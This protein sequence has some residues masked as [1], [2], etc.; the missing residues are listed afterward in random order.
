MENVTVNGQDVKKYLSDQKSKEIQ[1]FLRHEM[2]GFGWMR[3]R[4]VATSNGT[5]NVSKVKEVGNGNI[6]CK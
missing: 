4:H 2:R 1:D 6:Q 5:R 3:S